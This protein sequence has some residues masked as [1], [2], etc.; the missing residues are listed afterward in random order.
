MKIVWVNR[1][2]H[3]GSMKQPRE[4]KIRTVDSEYEYTHYFKDIYS[5]YDGFSAAECKWEVKN[6]VGAEYH[7]ERIDN[8]RGDGW[9]YVADGDLPPAGIRVVA[10]S[11]E[12][13]NFVAIDSDTV[14]YHFRRSKKYGRDFVYPCWQP[15]Q[16]PAN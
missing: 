4:W 13:H 2:N 3:D 6:R 11:A 12:N 16:S 14:V 10:W 5:E 9:F 15:I 1:F 8:Q 7:V